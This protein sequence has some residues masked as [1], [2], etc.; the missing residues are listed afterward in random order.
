MLLSQAGASN[1]PPYAA[2]SG[3][4]CNRRN[5]QDLGATSNTT[6]VTA[7]TPQFCTWTALYGAPVVSTVTGVTPKIWDR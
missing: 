4:N 2:P 1:V 3:V 7:V 5:L 6:T